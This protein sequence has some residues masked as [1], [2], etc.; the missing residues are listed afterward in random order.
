MSL[1]QKLR[2]FMSERNG[3][4]EFT[5]AIIIVY[6]ILGFL[7]MF[8]GS[9][10]IYIIE[11]ALFIYS[12]FRILSKNI[13]KRRNES[14]KYSQIFSDFK[15]KVKL[16]FVRIKDFRTYRYKKCPI[17][18]KTLRLPRKKGKHTVDCPNCHNKF[19]MTILF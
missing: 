11:T 6:I 13:Y 1:M 19:S 10:I 16:F 3:L 14:A 4:D 18:K 15:K 7:N 17:C 5:L 9:F 12:V 8:I 2:Q